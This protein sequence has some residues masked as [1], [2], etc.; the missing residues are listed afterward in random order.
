M[1][2]SPLKWIKSSLSTC[3]FIVILNNRSLEEH[4][5]SIVITKYMWITPFKHAILYLMEMIPVMYFIISLNHEK[6]LKGSLQTW[7]YED[8]KKAEICNWKY[9]IYYK[10]GIVTVK[11]GIKKA[12]EN[13][14][15]VIE[16]ARI[17]NITNCNFY[18]SLSGRF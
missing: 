11:S 3:N 16:L 6:S 2:K 5:Y 9:W 14:V 18:P 12:D 4:I 10:K 7:F 1:H 8:N 15:C 13:Q 17:A